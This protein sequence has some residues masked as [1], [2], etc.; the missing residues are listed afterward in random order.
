MGPPGGPPDFACAPTQERLTAAGRNSMLAAPSWVLRVDCPLCHARPSP[1]PP[2][3]PMRFLSRRLVVGVVCGAVA[4]LGAGGP[5][6]NAWRAANPQPDYLRQLAR[7]DVAQRF[8]PRLSIR[9]AYRRCQDRRTEAGA[10]DLPRSLCETRDGDALPSGT[11][12]DISASAARAARDVG[13]ITALHATALADLVWADSAGI[14]LDLAITHLK[15]VAR[16]SSRPT[17]VLADLAAA[18]LVRAERRQTP[19]DLLEAL[20][21]AATAVELDSL[22][23]AARFNLALALDRLMLTREAAAAWQAYLRTE[24]ASERVAEARESAPSARQSRV[25][26]PPAALQAPADTLAAWA[27]GAPQ[28]AREYGWDHLLGE[29]GAATLRGDST[30]AARLVRTTALIGD[31]LERR[32]GDA[33]LA[34]AAR[35]LLGRPAGSHARRRLRIV[36]AAHRTFAEGRAFFIAENY[37]AARP[38]FA[39]VVE[40]TDT[41]TPLHQWAEYYY[42]A[43]LVQSGRAREAEAALG[44]LLARAEP[45]RRRALV[46]H[47]LRAMGSALMWRGDHEGALIQLRTATDLFARIGEHEN[48]GAAHFTTASALYILGDLTGLDASMYRA[49]VALDGYDA[50]PWLH[51][52]LYVWGQATARAGLRRAAVLLQNEGVAVA[53]RTGSP[54]FVAEAR[55]ARARLLMAA[56]AHQSAQTDVAAAR[57]VIPQIVSQSARGWMLADLRLAEATLLFEYGPARAVGALDSAVAFFEA[58]LNP[59]RL[60]PALIT[61]AE[62]LLRL[63]HAER[64]ERDLERAV[65]LIEEQGAAVRSTPLRTSLLDATRAVL[66]RLVMLRVARGRPTGA[67][68]LLERGRASLASTAGTTSHATLRTTPGAEAATA[69]ADRAQPRVLA[70]PGVT[71]VEYALVGDTLLAWTVADTAVRLTRT[72]VDRDRLLQ[73]VERARTLL[74]VRAGDGAVGPDLA[75]LYDWLVRPIAPQLRAADMP[76]LLV[77][78]GELAGVPFAALLDTASRHYLV[79]THTLRFASSLRGLPGERPGAKRRLG[80]GVTAPGLKALLI[81]DPDFDV[82]ANPGLRRLPGASAE[83][84]ALAAEYVGSTVLHGSA[85]RRDVV[86]GAIPRAAVVHFAGHAVFDDDVPEQSRLV[87][88][89]NPTDPGSASDLSAADVERL[90]LQDVRLVVL[91]A[92]ETLRGHGGRSGG[93]AGL[94]GAFLAAGADGVVGSLWRV[95]DALTRPLMLQLHRAYRQTG[96]GAEALRRAQVQMIRSGTDEERSPAAWGAFRFAGP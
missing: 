95:D 52:V 48:L 37:E 55:L 13:D 28:A 32:G 22:N 73:T 34:D 83:V 4:A 40:R 10:A 66:D 54:T 86:A 87:L 15:A 85:A 11:M 23:A 38:L 69:A 76:L 81:A 58:P 31:A 43:T 44:R 47:A 42:A 20:E 63:G 62:A 6:R 39:R 82:R 16:V 3:A 91:S 90:N 49:R 94:S 27:T 17:P 14:S 74:E 77:A 60:L 30:R 67:L 24:S 53:T 56:G 8:R 61:R 70:P 7:A 9:T 93:F 75:T 26:S 64:A 80:P 41:A 59:V 36:A 2:G 21:A 46:A 79:E 50:S 25:A 65:A 88:A 51:N 78:D 19:R 35:T 96:D 57:E 92:C 71:G 84:R 72:R 18:H 1:P 12:L 5:L 89:A 29:W 33:T 45:S 68:A